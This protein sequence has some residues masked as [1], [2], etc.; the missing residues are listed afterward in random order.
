MSYL[1]VARF[2]NLWFLCTHLQ[3]AL[4][5]QVLKLPLST[6]HVPLRDTASHS[7]KTGAILQKKIKDPE[8]LLLTI[9]CP[10]H[11]LL[12]L[13]WAEQVI[14]Q[15]DPKSNWSSYTGANL[16]KTHKDKPGLWSLSVLQRER[17]KKKSTASHRQLKPF[18]HPAA[19][20]HALRVFTH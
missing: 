11:S 3:K 16:Y 10:T 7:S 5:S 6:A 19:A 14:T 1:R 18:P 2:L 13:M 20:T 17:Q 9:K 15:E 12:N 4:W 8:N